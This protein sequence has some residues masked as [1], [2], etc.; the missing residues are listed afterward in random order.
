MV[1]FFLINDRNLFSRTVNRD[2]KIDRFVVVRDGI[3]VDFMGLFGAKVFFIIGNS[4]VLGFAG[5]GKKIKEEAGECL[6]LA[7]TLFVCELPGGTLD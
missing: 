2:K 6:F 1:Y 3:A 5:F 4:S 7:V